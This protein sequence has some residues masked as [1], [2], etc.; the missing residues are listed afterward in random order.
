LPLLRYALQEGSM[1]GRRGLPY[2][3]WDA[4]SGDS[5]AINR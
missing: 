4:R 3:M 5:C 1:P 2:Q